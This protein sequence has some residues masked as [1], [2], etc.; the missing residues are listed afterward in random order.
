MLTPAPSRLLVAHVTQQLS[1]MH[2]HVFS[3]DDEGHVLIDTR[4]LQ[5]LDE[6]L[7]SVCCVRNLDDGVDLH[8]AVIAVSSTSIHIM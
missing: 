6:K 1:I 3:H 5:P 4:E 2:A 8:E 7:C